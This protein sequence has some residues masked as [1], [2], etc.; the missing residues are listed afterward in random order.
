M[1]SRNQV[2]AEVRKQKEKF[3]EKYCPRTR[4]LWMTGGGYCPRHNP[5]NTPSAI[6]QWF[7][8][9]YTQG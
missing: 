9:H 7:D 5:T 6:R 3:P 8:W 1:K 4:C 2:A